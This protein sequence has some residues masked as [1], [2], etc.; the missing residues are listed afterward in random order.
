MH[1]YDL[2]QGKS[3]GRREAVSLAITPHRAQFF[4]LS[5]EPLAPVELQVAT[6]AAPGSRQRVQLITTPLAGER[7]VKLTIA[8]PNG[9]PAHWVD[10]VVLVDNG[11]CDVDVPL[12]FNDPAGVWTVTATELYTG[13]TTSTQFRVE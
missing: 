11:S 7:A 5:P 4:A 12:A 8:L 1:V 13:N 2:K 9:Q 10:R 6:T 3:M